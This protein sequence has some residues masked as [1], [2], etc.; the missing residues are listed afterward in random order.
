M[1]RTAH[2]I[3]RPQRSRLC[4]GLAWAVF[5]LPVP[6]H[7]QKGSSPKA[8]DI[9]IPSVKLPTPNGWDLWV[10]A[11]KSLV[12]GEEGSP[13]TSEKL[14]PAEDLR[15]QRAAVVRNMNALNLV[16][17]GLRLPVRRPPERAANYGVYGGG[18]LRQLARLLVQQGRVQTA[19]GNIARA[20]S[21][22]LDALE[23]AARSSVG[24]GI[25]PYLTSSAIET[26]VC[27]DIRKLIPKTDS[28]TARSCLSRLKPINRIWPTHAAAIQEDKWATLSLMNQILSTPQWKVFRAGKRGLDPLLED[29][30]AA[31]LRK[32]RSL[33]DKQLKQNYVSYMNAQIA[34]ARLPYISTKKSI[35]RPGDSLSATFA[36]GDMSAMQAFL[37]SRDQANRDMLRTAVALRAYQIEHR[38][39]PLSLGALTPKFMVSPP[40]DP[41]TAA[42]PFRYKRTRTGYSLYSVGPDGKDNGGLTLRNGQTH[43]SAGDIVYG[44]N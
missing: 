21:S 39:F 15:R 24:G 37:F 42:G 26:L 31:D 30:T 41:F 5:A 44:V 43:K 18:N 20:M 22:Y 25:T 36:G 40:Q 9:S 7:A 1:R 23:M 8:P 17:Q 12:P 14:T 38:A 6:A 19:D 2:T 11:G 4:I 10:R 16:R 33:N 27:S 34:R 35:P 3:D 13:A 29:V 28:V 32:I